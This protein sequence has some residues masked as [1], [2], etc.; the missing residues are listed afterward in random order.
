[1]KGEEII[2]IGKRIYGRH[3]W[4]RDLA[5][6][7]GLNPS[8]IWRLSRLE[9]DIKPMFE[10]AIRG[11]LEKH[12]QMVEA[13]KTLRIADARANHRYKGKLTAHPRK[14]RRKR[15]TLTKED[16]REEISREETPPASDVR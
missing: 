12:R 10:V 13:Q 15:R 16:P 7:L 2:R 6:N 8:T 3:H 5:L 14:P 11:L 4:R 9:T 1:M